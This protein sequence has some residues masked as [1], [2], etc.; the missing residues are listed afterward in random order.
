MR[1]KLS[2]YELAKR[3]LLKPRNA[4]YKIQ[5]EI[6]EYLRYNKKIIVYAVPNGTFVKNPITRII[7][8]LIGLL[9]GCSDL[10]IL[11]QGGKSLYVEI[12]KPKEKQSPEQIEFQARIENLSHTY[13]LWRS[14]DDC[15]DYFKGETKWENIIWRA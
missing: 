15:I 2:F 13:L 5:S 9:A 3:E 6:V 14:L 8:G 10:V 1:R 7:L 4:E 11:L 12:K